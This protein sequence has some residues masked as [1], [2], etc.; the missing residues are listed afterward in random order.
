MLAQVK[1]FRRFN[2]ID[3]GSWGVGLSDSRID[4]IIYEA[5]KDLRI[6][7]IGVYN[8]KD[9]KKHKLTLKYKWLI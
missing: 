2:K 8:A 1:E 4:S 3:N 7:G 5:K 9:N 6:F